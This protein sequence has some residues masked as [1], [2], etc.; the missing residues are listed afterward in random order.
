MSRLAKIPVIVPVDVEVKINGQE[1]LIQGKNG[2]LKKIINSAIEIKYTDNYLVFLSREGYI[3]AK[4][5][6]GTARSLVYGMIIGVTEGFVKKLQL[7]GVGYRAF[8]K[9]DNSVNLLLG[10]SHP[11]NYKL[12]ANIIAECPTQTEII[13]RGAD[14]QLVGQVA[15]DLRAYRPP[16]P[17][18]GKGIRYLDEIIR[19]KET[20][21]K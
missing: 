2:I 15:A 12:P 5:Q 19:T 11:I 14:K 4:A 13:L 16:E 9:D 21:K 17:Y 20:K 18:K 10:F 8:I 1:I 7:I 3:D 6:A